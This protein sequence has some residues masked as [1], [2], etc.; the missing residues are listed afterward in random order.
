MVFAFR[1]SSVFVVALIACVGYAG[2]GGE[3]PPHHHA[4]APAEDRAVVD[5]KHAELLAI[6]DAI[7]ASDEQYYGQA[8]LAALIAADTTGMTPESLARHDFSLGGESYK[9]GD[10][11]TAEEAFLRCFERT[12][13]H[14][15]L[16]MAG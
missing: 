11:R 12:G 14:L 6:A 8:P 4:P 10:V 5:A 16:F 7:F 9:D 2:C 1:N 13:S 15:A 3:S